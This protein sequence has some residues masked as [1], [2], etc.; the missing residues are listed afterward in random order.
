MVGLHGPPAGHDRQKVILFGVE[1]GG[2]VC[3]GLVQEVTDEAGRIQ[4]GKQAGWF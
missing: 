2:G 4:I 3:I 1:A